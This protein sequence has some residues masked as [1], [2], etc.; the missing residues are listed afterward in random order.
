MARKQLF[1]RTAV[2]RRY[3]LKNT[4]GAYEVDHLISIELGGSNDV[5]NLW[6]Q[7]Y[8]TVW[9]AHVKDQLENELH[10]EV[11]HNRISLLTAQTEIRTNWVRSYQLHFHRSTPR[12]VKRK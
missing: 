11:C 10:R 6:P 9:N 5:T 2:Y 12:P 8:S 3:K 4:P 7:S 1:P